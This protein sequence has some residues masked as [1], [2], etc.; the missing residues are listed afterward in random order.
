MRSLTASEGFTQA[1]QFTESDLKD[2]VDSGIFT[3]ADVDRFRKVMVAKFNGGAVDEQERFRLVTGYSDIFATIACL[4]LLF[5]LPVLLAGDENGNSLIG[6]TVLLL[7]GLGLAEQFIR[8]HRFALTGIVL[9][10]TLFIC[11]TGIVFSLGPDVDVSFMYDSMSFSNVFGW[12]LLSIGAGSVLLGWVLWRRY[13]VPITAAIASLSVILCVMTY[14]AD[15]LVRSELWLFWWLMLFFGLLVFTAA[16]YLDRKD[17]ARNSIISDV[18]FWMHLLAAPLIT[19]PVFVWLGVFES[20]ELH[21][22][23][24]VTLFFLS[25]ILVS[26]LIDRRS[27]IVSS[28]FYVVA[29]FVVYL[30]TV[31]H[32]TTRYGSV[33]ML[34]VG[35]VLLLLSA[36]WNGCRRFALRFCPGLLRQNLRPLSQG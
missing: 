15:F 1:M 16:I 11:F 18:A 34:S 32:V 21:N 10:C 27:L 4:F 20:H 30:E 35:L 8:R 31:M 33:V 23:L 6:R 24:F 19:H 7:V 17:M 5:S 28:L 36:F 26:L 29:V 9:V 14:A 25:M 13:R 2:A 3:A 22:L 12:Q